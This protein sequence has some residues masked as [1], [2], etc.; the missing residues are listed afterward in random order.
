MGGSRVGTQPAAGAP[1]APVRVYDQ[2]NL[3]VKDFGFRNSF[4]FTVSAHLPGDG[5]VSLSGTAGPI[6]QQDASATPFSGHLEMK[7]I[8]PL[9]AGFVD[10]SDGVTGLVGDMVLDASWNGQ[11]MHVTKLEVDSPNITLV[12]SNAPS[13]SRHPRG[14][15]PRGRRCSKTFRWI[16][17]RSR[18]DR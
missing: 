15:I 6:N 8:D 11:Q 9:A 7:H 13:S 12:R 3:E 18:M 2:V 4:P 1:G 5:T 17:H 14:P 10:A 16:A